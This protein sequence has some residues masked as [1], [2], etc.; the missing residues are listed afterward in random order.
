MAA[1][2]DVWSGASFKKIE[3]HTEATKVLL[4][5]INA[6]TVPVL[7]R[8]TNQT[9]TDL[10][11]ELLALEKIARLGG[12]VLNTQK[13]AVETIRIYRTQNE[14]EKMIDLVDSLM[15][16]R[17]QT[18]QVQSAMVAEA[19]VALATATSSSSQDETAGSSSLSDV[20]RFTLLTKLSV[21]TEGRIHVELEHARF[22]A[23]L[24]VIAIG[25]G[26]KREAADM[27]AQLQV[28]TITNMP[29]LEKLGCLC[30]QI[31]LSLELGDVIKTPMISRKVN[32]RALNR[33]DTVA[34][35][36]RYFTLMRRYYQQK[37]QHLL[38]ARCWY[39]EFLTTPN[40]DDKITALSN[41]AIMSLIAE[42][43]SA[44][45][46][47]DAAECVAF[48]PATLLADRKTALSVLLSIKRMEHE[49]SSI[50]SIVTAFS[51]AGLIRTKIATELQVLCA[52]HP[53]LG[54]FPARQTH[55]YN[56]ASEHDLLVVATY[57]TRVR[58][59]RLSKLVG[60]SPDHTERFVMTLVADKSLYAKMD[61]LEGLI[62]FQ[63]QLNCAD[64]VKEWNANVEK[65]V[66]L[67]DRAAHLVVKERMLHN[68]PLAS[69]GGGAVSATA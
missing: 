46:V 50:H 44:K 4:E 53:M 63:R 36:I 20:E 6:T 1:Q 3:D 17:A 31:E 19:S 35:K 33:P 68:L 57:Y 49:L 13:L 22:V 11:E 66:G 5:K 16:R 14:V 30:D 28:E 26:R 2:G 41:L 21:V 10:V 38:E 42:H 24:A 39:E 65:C 58:L 47:D 29:R 18:K 51:G 54:E 48:A 37:E 23:Q 56:R 25:E 64:V 43:Q 34:I 61:R 32:Y 8:G 59:D 52:N 69:S 9:V 67:V 7:L 55:F 15:K 62:V 12:D 60:L 27:L 40:D 45:E